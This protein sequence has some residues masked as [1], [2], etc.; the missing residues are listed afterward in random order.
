MTQDIRLDFADVKAVYL[1]VGSDP[2]TG[3]AIDF[4]ASVD[5]GDPAPVGLVLELIVTG[6]TSADGLAFLEFAWSA[7][8]SDFSDNSNLDTVMSIDCV[9]SG[10]AKKVTSIEVKAQFFKARLQN[11][12]GGTIDVTTSN[13]NLK[14][15]PISYDQA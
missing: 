2:S 5:L 10:D 3:G 4:S 1:Q 11:E 9:A 15:Y 7:D 13:T 8:D 6:L 12:T 14:I